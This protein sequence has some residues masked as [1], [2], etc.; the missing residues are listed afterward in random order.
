MGYLLFIVHIM[1]ENRE[2]LGVE[3]ARLAEAGQALIDLMTIFDEAGS[4]LT[5]DEITMCFDLWRKY[6]ML[7]GDLEELPFPPND[8]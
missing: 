6:C 1:H 7:T 5:S 4:R 2:R 3:G 8:T